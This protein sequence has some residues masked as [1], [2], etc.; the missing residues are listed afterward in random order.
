MQTIAEVQSSTV[1]NEIK[2]A[3]IQET[4]SVLEEHKI[5]VKIYC[6]TRLKLFKK[7]PPISV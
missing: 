4:Y 3:E 7:K 5:K 1:S 6:K 2:I